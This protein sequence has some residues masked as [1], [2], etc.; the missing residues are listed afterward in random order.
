MPRDLPVVTLQDVVMS[1]LRGMKVTVNPVKSTFQYRVRDQDND[2]HHTGLISVEMPNSVKQ[3]LAAW[4]A[5]DVIPAI[6][7]KEGM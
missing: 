2:V 5:A 3:D 7:E 1:D 6:N 4:I